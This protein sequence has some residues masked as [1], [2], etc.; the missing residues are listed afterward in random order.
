VAFVGCASNTPQQEW[1]YATFEACRQETGAWNAKLDDVQPNG[2]MHVSAE[3]TQTDLNKVLA[4]MQE[5]QQSQGRP[6][7]KLEFVI[8]LSIAYAIGRSSSAVLLTWA[9][10][11]AF[12]GAAYVWGWLIDHDWL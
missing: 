12:A 1:A 4:C 11:V 5:K 9:G 8:Q 7:V 6:P 3:Q 2:F 10:L